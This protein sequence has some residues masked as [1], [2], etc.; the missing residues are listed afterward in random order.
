MGL[1]SSNTDR[2]NEWGKRA[3]TAAAD[4][5]KSTRK[6]MDCT[7]RL[8]TGT[9]DDPECDRYMKRQHEADAWLANA[10]AKDFAAL[11][12]KPPWWKR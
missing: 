11:A 10:N 2:S 9:S 6:A 1:F 4:A 12:A 5:R 7:A 8:E 3:K